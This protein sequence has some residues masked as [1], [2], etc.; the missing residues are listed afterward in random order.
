MVNLGGPLCTVLRKRWRRG[1][2]VVMV[3]YPLITARGPKEN[4]PGKA[5]ERLKEVRESDLDAA[6]H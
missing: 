3:E 2:W 4:N 6:M 5:H 1:M